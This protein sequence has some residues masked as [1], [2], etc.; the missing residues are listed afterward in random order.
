MFEICKLQITRTNS[1]F[2]NF[3]IF[4]DDVLNKRCERTPLKS[5]YYTVGA[6]SLN[7]SFVSNI[8]TMH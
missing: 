4:K 6:C 3:R 7:L 2:L 1:K 5:K 8:S